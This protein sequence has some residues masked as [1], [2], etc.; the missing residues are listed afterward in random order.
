M[1]IDAL[2]KNAAMR[3]SE[4]GESESAGEAVGRTRDPDAPP[5]P[6]GG[7]PSYAF[8]RRAKRGDIFIDVCNRSNIQSI[9]ICGIGEIPCLS[10]EGATSSQEE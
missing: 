4:D 1:K 9:L 5:K 2:N 6:R 3:P 8:V 7:P 10:G